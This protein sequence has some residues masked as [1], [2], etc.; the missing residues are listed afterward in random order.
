MNKQKVGGVLL[1]YMNIV[2][3]F[4]INFLITPLLI[5]YLTDD[6]YSLYKVIHSFA[7]PL[8]ILNLGVSTI[9]ARS[10]ARYHATPD[11]DKRE[12]QNTLFMAILVS[13]AMALLVVGVAYVLKFQIPVIY[14]AN[15]TAEQIRVAEQIFM[16][17]AC[18]TAVHILTDPFQ[19]C[20][21]GNEKFV[22]HYGVRLL[23]YVVRFGL[24][25]V[26]VKLGMDVVAISSVELINNLLVLVVAVV[27]AFVV[28]KEVPK[29]HYLDKK[30]LFGI[31]TFSFSILLQ[32]IINQVN[33]NVDLMILGNKEADK[34]VITMYSSALTIY[35]VY[36]SLITV[37]SSICFP[38]AARM[39]TKNC[40]KK[41]LTDFVIAPGRIQ[42]VI[43]VGVVI[44]F[45]LLGNNFITVWI[46]SE[47]SDAYY[48][49]LM[50]L[51]PVSIP[52]VQNVCLAILDAQ[53]KRLFRSIVLVIMA[54]LNVVFS[55]VMYPV[56]GVWGVAL[57]TTLSLCIG[58]ILIMNIYYKK[59]IGLEVGRMFR[60]IFRGTLPV[61]LVTGVLCLPM[62]FFFNESWIAFLIKSVI[63]VGIYGAL[64]WKFGLTAA[65]KN[66]LMR[67]AKK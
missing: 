46:G 47:Y 18:S 63:F 39:V 33:N 37:F 56:I 43:A 7:G 31:V 49:V 16:I 22:F 57:G 48:I 11:G 12:K 8:V 21:S 9:V 25:F 51:I 28:L 52:L 20:A 65:D 1:S 42:A 24:I 58:H 61:G 17:F 45:A 4:V 54:V 34:A 29:F 32:A 6:M 55:I 27:Y 23:Q 3:G 60:E 19:G 14:G 66:A 53:L 15:Y 5:D 35:T 2:C 30:E 44:A 26:F 64:L 62:A 40:S 67:V 10:I 59:V 41:Q 50:L 13:T 36:N 38:S